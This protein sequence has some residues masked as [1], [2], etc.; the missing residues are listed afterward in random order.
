M[1]RAII[2]LI[3]SL[4]ALTG[5]A[6]FLSDEGNEHSPFYVVPR[7]SQLVLHQELT[8]LGDE[9]GVYIQDGRPQ[10][11]TDVRKYY[12]HCK[13]ELYS[14]RSAVR[15]VAPDTFSVTR[16][17][18]E[19]SHSAQQGASLYA[20]ALAGVF[21]DIDND[22]P[23]RAFVTRMYLH[24]AKQPDVFRLS[25]AQWGYPPQDGH[26]TIAEMRHALGEVFALQLVKP[27]DATPNRRPRPGPP[28]AA[29]G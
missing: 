11:F 22:P 29:G 10:P 15:K 20:Q 24:S 13:F 9:V 17:I 25:C 4:T 26:V 27:T 18:Q 3:A 6:G 7:G 23:L 8:I 16:V 2:T 14:L 19:E 21:T 1:R 12:P 5:C 28:A